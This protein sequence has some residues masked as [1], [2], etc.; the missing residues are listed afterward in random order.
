MEILR[1]DQKA[2]LIVVVE[3]KKNTYVFLS[4]DC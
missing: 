3:N 2:S 1:L 4:Y